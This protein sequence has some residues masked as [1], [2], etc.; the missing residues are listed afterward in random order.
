MTKSLACI[1]LFLLCLPAEIS[2]SNQ[3]FAIVFPLDGPAKSR[4]LQWL[5]EGIAM[6]LS[7]QL[8]SREL[9]SM[10]RSERTKLV[11]N[12]DL[13]RERGLAGEA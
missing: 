12:L 8:N 2:A 4:A 6:S 10:G 3:L 1:L 7:D 9:K 5:G 11:E 13:P